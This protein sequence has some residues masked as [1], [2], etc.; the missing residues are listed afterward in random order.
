MLK[1]SILIINTPQAHKLFPGQFTYV[2]IGCVGLAESI[3][4]VVLGILNM[5]T[6]TCSYCYMS[7]LFIPQAIMADDSNPQMFLIFFLTL[8]GCSLLSLPVTWC[9]R[10]SRDKSS[11]DYNANTNKGFVSAE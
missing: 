3:S 11:E 8:A 5:V 4:Y 9:V 7:K 10:E 1:S 2:V 6:T